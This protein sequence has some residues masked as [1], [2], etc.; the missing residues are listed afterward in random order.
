MRVQRTEL[1]KA[2]GTIRRNGAQVSKLF[3]RNYS[4]VRSILYDLIDNEEEN[5]CLDLEAVKATDKVNKVTNE[6]VEQMHQSK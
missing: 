6:K 5:K 1:T 3:L 2:R 4:R